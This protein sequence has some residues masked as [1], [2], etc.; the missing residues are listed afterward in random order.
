MLVRPRSRRAAPVAFVP[1][2]HQQTRHP[3][4]DRDC[5][6]TPSLVEMSPRPSHPPRRPRWQHSPAL[7]NAAVLG[8]RIRPP[9]GERLPVSRCVLSKARPGRSFRSVAQPGTRPCAWCRLRR[10]IAL[11]A[12]VIA[13]LT[14]PSGAQRPALAAEIARRPGIPVLAPTLTRGRYWGTLSACIYAH[15]LPTQLAV[16]R[17]HRTPP[18]RPRRPTCSRPGCARPA[19]CTGLLG[20]VG[21]AD[22][23]PQLLASPLTTPEATELQALLALDGRTRRAPPWPW[24]S[25]ATRWRWAG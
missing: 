6:V 1:A 12:G 7:V 17:H 3:T 24:R 18:G 15:P 9:I 14:D 23:R 25:P 5:S 8:I 20:T 11:G 19:R 10:P 22:R 21:D 16:H 4:Q 13:V 2:E